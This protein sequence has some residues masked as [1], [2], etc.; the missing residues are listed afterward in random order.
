VWVLLVWVAGVDFP[1]AGVDFSRKKHT[2]KTQIHTSRT[3]KTPAKHNIHTSRKKLEIIK[4]QHSTT[5][6]RGL[7]TT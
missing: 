4:L 6:C 5:V 3:E 7:R 2:S 1:V